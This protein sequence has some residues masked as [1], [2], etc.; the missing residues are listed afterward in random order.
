MGKFA[1]YVESVAADGTLCRPTSGL[2]RCAV[3]VVMAV[4][5]AACDPIADP[6]LAPETK[7]PVTEIP[8]VRPLPAN[9]LRNLY[10][11]DLHIHTALSS[12]AFAMGVRA[13]PADVYRFSRG[14]TIEHGAGYPL[15]IRRPL[16]FA[17]VTDHAEY[18]GQARLAGLDIPTTRQ[19]LAQLL[20]E[21]SR[22][23]VTRAWVETM[24]LMHGN[25]FQL[26]LRG[27]DAAINASA[28]KTT[29]DAANTY[30]EPGKFT[31]FIGWEWSADGGDVTTHLH[32]NIIYGESE[33]PSRPFS[34]IDG[35]KAPDLWRFLRSER[36]LGRSVIAIPHNGNLSQGLM[37]RSEDASGR[38]LVESV[39]R[40]RSELEPLSE[41]LQVKGASE[42]HPLLSSLDEFAGF[43]IASAVPGQQG[44]LETVT[45]SY[46]RDALRRG[47][48][49]AHREGF[50]PF[51][52]GVIGASDSHNA[53]SV[54]DEDNHTGKL[55]MMDGSAGLR[56]GEAGLGLKYM[57]PAPSWGSGGLAGVWAEDNTRHALFSALQRRET[58]AT[59]GPR[60]SLR[61]FGGWQLDQA[62][63]SLPDGITQ[64]DA[65]GVPMGSALPIRSG[66]PAPQFVIFAAQDPL[67]AHLDRIQIIKGWV[68]VDG[69]THESVIDVAW[70][71]GRDI[72]P[73]TGRLD[74]VGSTVNTAASSYENTIGT[75]SL[76][77]WWQDDDFNPD[78]P[79]FYYPR[80]LE[81]PTPRWSTYD[82]RDLGIEPMS[83]VAIQERAIGSAIWYEPLPR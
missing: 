37:Y 71:P 62:L 63:A 80:V 69:V 57:T 32:R 1:P 75:P 53:S 22:L 2:P 44:T 40:D 70:S 38:L 45:G 43:E 30:N 42:T 11:G 26:T 6:S 8:E 55:P 14:L 28:W 17:A 76:T 47:I 19:P 51:T 81:I 77:A 48:S 79:A 7:P 49:L 3:A 31:A 65:R 5:I 4:F 68:D 66:S 35:P 18:M 23:A 58:F 10:W 29:V 54:T 52:F 24:A 9:P 34:A 61:M 33:V 64:A 78:R 56:T 21:G 59:S 13:L 20:E 46:A 83:P 67:G 72:D 60:L 25:G 36:A 39:P 15:T 27:V 74:P 12:D 41:I 82:A 50:N 16:D 73:A